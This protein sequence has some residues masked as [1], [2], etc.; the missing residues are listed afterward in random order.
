MNLIF[1]KIRFI[2]FLLLIIPFSLL[3]TEE[4]EDDM[5][6][7]IDWEADY[8]NVEQ[9]FFRWTGNVEIVIQGATFYSDDLT[10]DKKSKILQSPGWARIVY[11]DYEVH[12]EKI[13]VNT[14]TKAGQFKNAHVVVDFGDFE[15][16]G[17]WYEKKW[18][19]Y[20]KKVVKDANVNVFHV[21]DGRATT[22]PPEYQ[23]P[24]YYIQAKKLS[25]FPPTPNDPESIGRFTARNCFLKFE[26]MPILWFPELTYTMH[27]NDDE[28]PLQLKAGYDSEK[29]AFGDVAFDIYKSENLKL[30]PHIGYYQ[31]HGLA[32][33]LDGS[34]FF[35]KTNVFWAEGKWET[36]FL[37][38]I[39]RQFIQ[40]SPEEEDEV[41]DDH[42]ENDK[43]IRY[44]FLWEH[45]QEFGEGAGWLNQGR[46]MWEVDLLSDIDVPLDFFR[47]D[48]KRH[49]PRDTWLDFT[50]PIGLDNEVSFYVVK[51]IND[52]YT[53]YERLPELRHV[54]KKRR[55]LTIPAL[56]IPVYYES[57]SKAGYYNYLEN[58][59][60]EDKANFSMYRTWTDHKISMPKRYFNFLN[61][62]PFF[63]I[64][65]AAGH[66]SSYSPGET[67]TEERRFVKR[68]GARGR[69]NSFTNI[70]ERKTS[71]F[72]RYPEVSWMVDYNRFTRMPI[73]AYNKQ[74][75]G[76]FFHIFPYAGFNMNFKMH[77]I[78]DLEGSYA[79]ELMR[80]YLSSDNEK[81]R[82]IIEPQ[83]KF[84]GVMGAGSDNNLAFGA[85]IGIRNAFQIKRK[86]RNVDLLDLTI[87][88]STRGLFDNRITDTTDDY[89]ERR[90]VKKLYSPTG[91]RIVRKGPWKQ[92]GHTK[93]EV[94]NEQ[95]SNALGFDWNASPFEW[96]FIEGDAIWDLDKYN[97]L[98]RA[99]FDS[100]YDLSWTVQ[101]FFA[102]PFIPRV[103][104]GRKDELILDVGYRYLYEQ[105][106]LIN[107]GTRIW[108]D[109]FT[110]LLSLELQQKNWALELSRGW[111][112]GFDVRFEAMSGTMQE[113]EFVIYKTW[114]KTMETS[115]GY[116][117]RDGE[118]SI[119]ATFWLTAY[120]GT[121]IGASN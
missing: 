101:E 121:K 14:E 108:F 56:D 69:E 19:I 53:T 97:K 81:I 98:T 6:N 47:D 22:T 68:I 41:D 111:G 43:T 66:I 75:K 27:E 85:D 90:K 29:G 2:I 18:Y 23:K 84:I 94:E 44:R 62:E 37:N 51:R 67:I 55:V 49:G 118:Q 103:L 74:E 46:L 12:G 36:F 52:F 33:G 26:G 65:A 15:R 104:R 40:E 116:K 76:T 32:L 11:Q 60:R 80:K 38:D 120:P 70:V 17:R 20:G 57:K 109:D 100:H 96:M 95:V 58:D 21:D 5:L 10:F 87:V 50:L 105:A 7:D 99:V 78:Y 86:G 59:D 114:K 45:T 8:F 16:D 4:K 42:L 71:V 34:Y 113:T 93:E 63:G 92:A 91:Q 9:G 39:S 72:N 30:T 54:F 24:L 64:A 79:G 107:A 82:H 48:Y 106:N 110:P 102:K 77:K 89:Y 115:I 25:I 13:I 73:T 112:F 119:M 83:A 35:E 3:A 28:F 88:H 1:D 31:K 61:V 117:M